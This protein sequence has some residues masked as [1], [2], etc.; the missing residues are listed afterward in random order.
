MKGYEKI[1]GNEE[2]YYMVPVMVIAI[3]SLTL[4]VAKFWMG[5]GRI[6]ARDPLMIKSMY[7]A[8]RHLSIR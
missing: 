2:T 1:S 6:N 8:P 3:Q 5:Y 4:C 7:K